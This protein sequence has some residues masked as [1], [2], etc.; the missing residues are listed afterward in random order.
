VNPREIAIDA[1]GVD[2]EVRVPVTDRPAPTVAIPDEASFHVIL[3]V[4]DDGSPALASYR[5][6]II[7]VPTAGTLAGDELRCAGGSRTTTT[8]RV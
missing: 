8:G 4:T 7:R 3:Q 2:A 1:R 5:R 6:A